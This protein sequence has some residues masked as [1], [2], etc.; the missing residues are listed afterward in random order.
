MGITLKI[1]EEKIYYLN[2]MREVL[3]ALHFEDV[4]ELL[5]RLNT[6]GLLEKE[7]I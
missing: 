6:Y 3:E 7:I 1:D 4:P 2:N 5:G